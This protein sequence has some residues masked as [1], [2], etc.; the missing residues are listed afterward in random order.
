MEA[1]RCSLATTRCVS[2]GISVTDSRHLPAVQEHSAL[3]T[4]SR[5][6]ARRESRSVFPRADA[7]PHVRAA[8][9]GG[10]AATAA[11]AAPGASPSTSKS[12]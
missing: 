8:G 12:E 3:T 6:T 2:R 4:K 5:R 10:P 11:G 7:S 1:G 9:A